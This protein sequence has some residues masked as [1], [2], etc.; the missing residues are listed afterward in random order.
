VF[1]R[2]EIE[3]AL[4]DAEYAAAARYFGVDRPPNFE[5]GAW[6]LQPRSRT[7]AFGAADAPVESARR[8]L[9]ALRE[10]RVRPGRDEKILTAWNG[11]AIGNL[12]KAARYLGRPELGLAATEAADFVRQHLWRSLRLKASFKDQRARFTAYLDDYAFMAFGL[13]ELMQWRFRSGDLGFAVELVDSLLEH[14]TDPAGGFFFTADDHEPLIHRPK[15]LADEAVPSG[16]G[17]AALA[18]DTLGHLLGESRYLEAA[19]GTVRAAA[20]A[21]A[22]HAEAHASLLRAMD[23]RLEPPEIVIVRGAGAE[24]DQWRSRIDNGFHPERLLF[25]I[26]DE[27]EDLPGLLASRKSESATTA[28]LC[29]GTECLPPIRSLSELESRL[30]A[31]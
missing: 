11:L 6:H 26:D 8:K 25:F 5:G 4:D 27:I 28:Y 10:Q 7:V 31:G 21:I 18:L 20:P 17:M 24:L 13:T 9:L 23:R 1:A 30:D 16:N 14:F 2:E 19:A 3:A 12:A 29:K 22:R 15:P